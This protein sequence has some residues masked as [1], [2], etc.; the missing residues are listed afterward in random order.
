MLGFRSIRFDPRHLPKFIGAAMR[1]LNYR[2]AHLF[3]V[4]P[5]VLCP[6]SAWARPVRNPAQLP[7]DRPTILD[8]VEI[9]CTGVSLEARR[10]PAWQ[11]YGLKVEV[12]GKGGQYLGDET[13]R[14]SKDGKPVL[15]AICGGPW[16]LFKL[17]PGRYRIDATEEGETASSAAYVPATG[18]GRIILR[19][20]TLGNDVGPPAV[21]GAVPSPESKS[22][23][24]A[25]P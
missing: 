7:F 24:P 2:L 15:V 10:N 23:A 11:D 13:V 9:V 21:N 12:A 17:A 18:Q 20:P 25:Q 3:A 5:A 14:V 4:V 8:G 22:T 16:I 19:F 6:G 1:G